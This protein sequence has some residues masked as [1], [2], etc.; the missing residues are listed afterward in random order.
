MSW[1]F[2]Q[3]LWDPKGTRKVKRSEKMIQ[4]IFFQSNEFS[5]FQKPLVLK[6]LFELKKL[7]PINV[8]CK[9]AQIHASNSIV[10]WHFKEKYF[11]I[12]RI[13]QTESVVEHLDSKTCSVHVNSSMSFGRIVILPLFC[14]WAEFKL[15][16]L[17][18][19]SKNK[20]LKLFRYDRKSGH[21]GWT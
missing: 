6:S 9:S 19:E 17:F 13:H 12:L 4:L 21:N 7:A 20:Q 16:Q 3:L 5:K 8:K 18:M 11:K 2:A 1:N 14:K 10:K 15:A